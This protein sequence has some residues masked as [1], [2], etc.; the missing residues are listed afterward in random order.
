M[1]RPGSSRRPRISQSTRTV[2]TGSAAERVE[3]NLVSGNSFQALGKLLKNLV[4][5]G[6]LVLLW[7]IEST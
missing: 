7:H 6:G 2:K 4:R 3:G 5:R 1:A